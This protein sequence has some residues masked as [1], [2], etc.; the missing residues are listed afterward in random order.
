M[1]Q[2]CIISDLVNHRSNHD[3]IIPEHLINYPTYSNEETLGTLDSEAKGHKF[4][5]SHHK[6]ETR[7]SHEE[8]NSGIFSRKYLLL[9]GLAASVASG[10]IYPQTQGRAV[11]RKKN[12]SVNDV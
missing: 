6:K 3:P 4:R 9:L 7:E 1:E 2:A 12:V 11:Q 10:A 8:K 5:K